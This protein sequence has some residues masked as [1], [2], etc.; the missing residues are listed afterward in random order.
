MNGTHRQHGVLLMQGKGIASDSQPSM[1][2]WLT[3]PT[4]F[5]RHHGR[6]IPDHMDEAGHSAAFEARTR[7][8]YTRQYGARGTSP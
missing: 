8:R 7:P 4:L 2:T 1:Q 3:R 5:S 6:T